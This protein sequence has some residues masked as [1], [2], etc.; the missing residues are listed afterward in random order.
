MRQQLL[1]AST[2]NAPL[3][4]DGASKNAALRVQMGFKAQRP[5]YLQKF[6]GSFNSKARSSKLLSGSEVNFASRK[7]ARQEPTAGTTQGAQDADEVGSLP[8]SSFQKN[9]L[10]KES[11]IPCYRQSKLITKANHELLTG[12]FE[13]LAQASYRDADKYL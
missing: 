8:I 11:Q 10:H 5:P 1:K 4:A 13:F 3:D 6:S 7:A 2:Q 9:K 12:F